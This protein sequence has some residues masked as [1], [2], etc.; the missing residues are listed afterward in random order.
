MAL[1]GWTNPQ[2][3]AVYTKRA[4]RARLEAAAAPLLEGRNGNKSVPLFPT[5]AAGGTLR[6][7]QARLSMVL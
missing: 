1:F 4:N 5:V 6:P 2:H 3:A 7:K